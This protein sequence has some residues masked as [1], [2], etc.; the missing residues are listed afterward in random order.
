MVANNIIIGIAGKKQSGKSSLCKFIEAWFHVTKKSLNYNILQEVNGDIS[1]FPENEQPLPEHKV[2][3]VPELGNIKIYSFAD[4]LKKMC[5][6]IL[7]LPEIACYG[8]DTDKNAPTKYLWNTL[9][10]GIRT[11]YSNKTEIL[12]TG[13]V[14]TSDGPAKAIETFIV[15]RTGQMT[16]REIMQVMGTDIFR[17]MFSPEVWVEA[18]FRLIKSENYPLALVADC[19]FPSE[20]DSIINNGGYIIRLDRVFDNT[21]THPSETALDN[22]PFEKLGSKCLIIRNNRIEINEKNQL[23]ADW[24]GKILI[25]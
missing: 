15:P 5:I 3:F 23:A 8:T 14:E 13:I 10:L 19:R 11:K 22:Y 17:D 7:G 6:D 1:L 4:S 18:T 2:N 25:K 21:D 12:E 24:L 9:P 16:G 20:V